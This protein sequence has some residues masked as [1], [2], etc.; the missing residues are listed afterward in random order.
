MILFSA[1]HWKCLPIFGQLL[2]KLQVLTIWSRVR[3]ILIS[4]SLCGGSWILHLYGF[5]WL[6]YISMESK[7]VTSNETLTWAIINLTN[8]NL[9][10]CHVCLTECSNCRMVLLYHP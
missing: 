9:Q 3:S 4:F 7:I 5:C 1:D 10:N 8:L 2:L 6:V